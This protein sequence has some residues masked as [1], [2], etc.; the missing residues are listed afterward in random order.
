[1][2]K[3]NVVDTHSGAFFS[4]KE[5]NHVIC[6]KMDE[7]GDHHVKQTK[8]DSERQTLCVFSHMWNLD[9]S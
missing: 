8:P 9:F 4:D 7:T 2:N 1:M 6:R 3:E 5:G